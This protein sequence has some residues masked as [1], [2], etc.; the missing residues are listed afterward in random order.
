MDKLSFTMESYIDAIY[1]LS[2]EQKGARLTDI[3]RRMNVTKSTANAAMVTLAK[4]Q[5]IENEHYR[6]IRL[7][8]SGAVM[9]RRITKKHE[10]IRRFFR[11]CLQIDDVTADTDACAIEH[12][13]SDQAVRAMMKHLDDRDH[14]SSEP[15]AENRRTLCE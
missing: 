14:P 5:L 11:E 10:V 4:K 13:I 15:E 7:T 8:E 6:D 2:S 9:A 3:A 12:L 1:E